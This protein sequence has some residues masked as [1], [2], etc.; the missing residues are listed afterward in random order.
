M[1]KF[2]K[3][4]VKTRDG[5]LEGLIENGLYVFKGIPYASP[6]VGQLRWLSP[7]PPL[8]WTG[9]RSVQ[10]FGTI[11]PQMRMEM[12]VNGPPMEAEPQ[13]EN[14]LFLNIFTP[15]LDDKK[16][17]V[18]VWI[19]GGAYNLGSGSSLMH[20]GHTL[21]KKGD[22]VFVS[23]NYRLGPLGFLHLV[24][25]TGGQIPASGNE[26]LLDQ[27]AALR[28]V[29]DNISGFGGDPSNVTIFG[30]SA[31][32]MSIGCLL[33]MP[34]ARGL[35]QKAILQ[36]G[37]STVRTLPEAEANADAFLAVL[38]QNGRQWEQLL[39]LPAANIIAQHK[40]WTGLDLWSLSRGAKLEPVI[41]GYSLPDWPLVA[42]KNGSARDVVIM[43]GTTLDESTIFTAMDRQLSAISEKELVKRLEK[44]LPSDFVSGLI[45]AY[46]QALAERGLQKVLPYH[47]FHA[48]F[49]DLQFRMPAVRLVESQIKLGSSAYYYIFDW[50][51]A[52]RGLG[53]C[54]SLEL[55]FLFGNHRADF[56]GAGP[57]A[58]KLADQIQSA[59]I[60]FARSGNPSCESLGRWP[61][62][63][64]SRTT[65]LLGADSRAVKAPFEAERQAWE[66]A[67]D[68][69]LG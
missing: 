8:G 13:D 51:S 1:A 61:S 63:G 60:A 2:K 56:H 18:M 9:K 19:H 7:Q 32:G 22:V 24:K 15:G 50:T 31:G 64:K 62:Y 55:G 14:C 42:C 27:I 12:S 10:K 17:P 52:I 66:K 43:A 33:S 57:A 28:W 65:M 67:P 59:W 20:P 30:E 45:P 3:P 11:A 39:A 68:Q 6:P 23:L 54:H 26:G 21:P 29:K 35:F 34:Q 58:E 36:S 25:A 46:S 53:A 38:G 48:I 5:I 40:N 4:V 44:F 49:T 47:L 41:D 16:R 37:V 69:W